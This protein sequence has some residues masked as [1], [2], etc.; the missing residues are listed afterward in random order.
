MGAD[1]SKPDEINE[2]ILD[3]YRSC[4]IKNLRECLSIYEDVFYRKDTLGEHEFDEIFGL[5]FGDAEK[6]WSVYA[7][8]GEYRR[9]ANAL[10]SFCAICL[11]INEV[12]FNA[13]CVLIYVLGS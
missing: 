13:G 5:V 1:T 4:T 6:H 11:I 3:D 8:E 12:I 9:V 7:R 2:L 10:E